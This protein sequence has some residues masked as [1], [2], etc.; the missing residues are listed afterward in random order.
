MFRDRDF[1]LEDGMPGR[2]EELSQDLELGT[3]FNAMAADDAFLLKVVKAAVLASLT[4]PENILYRQQILSDCLEFSDI[5]RDLYALT[6]EAYD[7]EKKMWGWLSSPSPGY[8]LRRAAD[9]LEMFLEL[10]H[11]LRRIADDHGAKFR[12]EGFRRFFEMIVREL[13]D[14]Y[15]QVVKSHLERLEFPGGVLMS[16]DLGSDFRGIHY[17]LHRLDVKKL[18][19]F[20]QLQEWITAARTETGYTFTLSDRDEAGF[21]ALKDLKA[22]GIA[23][24]AAA[25]DQSA[26]HILSFFNRL[27]IE[28]AFYV[29]CLNL[30][31]RLL[32]K[33][34]PLCLP[35][36]IRVDEPTLVCQG[37]YDVCLSLNMANRVVGNSVRGE[38]RS[39]LMITGANRGG[40]STF[41]R[42]AGLAQ[43]MMQCGMF[44]PAESFSANVS[45][46]IFTHFKREEDATM[47]SGKLDEELARMSA[48]VEKITPHSIIFLNESFASTNE[49]E[50]SEIARQIVRALLEMNVKVVYVTH[51]FDLAQSFFQNGSNFALFL[52][53]ER[54][55][56]GQRTFRLLEG[57]PLPTSYGKD[58][59]WRIFQTEPDNLQHLVQ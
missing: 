10:L 28:L 21:N 5:T 43:L 45:C 42:S 47:K 51:M 2:P 44:V 9:A 13:D 41:L 40:K 32:Q 8:V 26:N 31:D 38:N 39:L 50:G 30:R 33:G 12:S 25:I 57:E 14:D 56:D 59:F 29:G 48:I 6:V 1:Q 19:W 18:R 24:V 27:R 49:R 3:L 54:L 20:E 23:H 4:E 16:A 36:P 22:Q 52:R 17:V 58:L 46:G 7:R 55:D 35:D 37:L 15:L 11:Q 34:E 53:A